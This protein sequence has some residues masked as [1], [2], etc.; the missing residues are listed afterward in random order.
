MRAA[1]RACGESTKGRSS[2]PSAADAPVRRRI[3]V[4]DRGAR[5][6][7]LARR[8]R[9]R[10]TARS[11]R[12]HFAHVDEGDDAVRRARCRPIGHL[13]RQLYTCDSVEKPAPAADYRAAR[14]CRQGHCASRGMSDCRRRAGP[15]RCAH[16][17]AGRS[18]SRARDA[19]VRARA[20]A[21]RARAPALPR[22]ARARPS[23]HAPRRPHAVDGGELRPSRLGHRGPRRPL[24][25]RRRARLPR[26]QHRRQ[27]HLL[28][29]RPASRSS[30]A[31]QARVAAGPQFMLPTEDSIV[32]AEELGRRWGLP[33]WQFTLSAS[34]ANTE[35]LR[36]ARHATGRERVLMF[37]GDY[38]GHVD[39]FFVP[40]AADGRLSFSGLKDGRRPRR[41]RRAVQR[42][43]GARA[44]ARDRRLR[45]RAHRAG[46]DELGRRAA[47]HRA[48]TT[49][50]AASRASTARCSSST[51]RTRSSA[52][53]A[54][55]S[56]AGASSPTS[57]RPARRSAAASRSAPT[58]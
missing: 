8:A 49:P 54:A 18:R 7:A 33:S 38:A 46:A 21:L 11:S 31:V 5:G 26:H 50:C 43:R 24:H 29:L 55:W 22:A 42:R 20:R 48:S 4:S 37:T 32:V 23:R 28:R 25:L 1:K 15:V 10:E 34:Q 14:R 44:R 9:G 19:A 13:R 6:R 52:G 16:G 51:R 40:Y 47:R 39:E 3:R 58:A 41:R 35:A 53:L 30:R 57:S 36:L 56:G 17:R 27:E 45:L 12:L 2:F